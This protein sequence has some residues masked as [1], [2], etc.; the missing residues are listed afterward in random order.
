MVLFMGI[1]ITF[2]IYGQFQDEVEE[3]EDERDWQP[4]TTQDLEN[5]EDSASSVLLHFAQGQA[6]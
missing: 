5:D 2:F 1:S 6:S 3:E 4:L